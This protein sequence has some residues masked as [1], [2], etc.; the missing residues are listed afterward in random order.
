MLNIPLSSFIRQW[1]ILIFIY[2]VSLSF[3][4]ILTLPFIGQKIQPSEVIFLI[5]FFFLILNL[6]H[7]PLYKIKFNALDFA[8]MFYLVVIFIT[9]LFAVNSKPFFEFFGS[10][11]LFINYFLIKNFIIFFKDSIPDFIYK[12]IL[13][14]GLLAAFFGIIGTILTYIKIENSLGFIY[15]RY[16]YFGDIIRAKGFTSSPHMLASILNVSILFSITHFFFGQ[17]RN[18]LQLIAIC[19]MLLA[20]LLT[21]A[22]IV[23]LLLIG[24]IFIFILKGKNRFLPKPRKWFLLF[25]SMCLLIVYIM[26][27]HFI[28]INKNNS[29][30]ELIKKERFNSGET[31]Y[32]NNNFYIFPTTYT[33]LKK[34][35][36]YLGKKNLFTGI[37]AGNHGLYF[38]DLKKQGMFP[39]QILN[40]DPHSSY[41]G[42]FAELGILGLISVLYLFFIIK[43]ISF[44]IMKNKPGIIEISLISCLLIFSLEAISADILNFRHFWVIL[45]LLSSL[46]SKQNNALQHK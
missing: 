32:E 38:H 9:S 19:I 17:K 10:T 25:C 14:M 24:I 5:T 31:I 12:A 15:V 40:Y 28:I 37:G 29:E 13:W 45:A 41:F 11:Y 23:V 6:K 8:L 39:K 30:L 21:F 18:M 36:I 26:G 4:K 2:I 27:T 3:Q 1:S 43:K 16:P 42:S 22:K 7:I 44:L 34:S 46:Y 20:Y 33:V 35:S